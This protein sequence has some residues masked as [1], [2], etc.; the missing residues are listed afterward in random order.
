MYYTYESLDDGHSSIIEV[1]KYLI[2]LGNG[3]T[4]SHFQHV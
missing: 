4:N 1:N 3:N 2:P